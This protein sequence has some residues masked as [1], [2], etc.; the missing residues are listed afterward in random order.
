MSIILQFPP[1]KNYSGQLKPKVSVVMKTNKALLGY[2][3]NPG[4]L[5]ELEGIYLS[6]S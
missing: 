1:E 6:L 4:S 5:P 3:W 2:K